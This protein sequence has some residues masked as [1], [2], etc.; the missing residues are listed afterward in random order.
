MP[1][2]GKEVAVAMPQPIVGRHIKERDLLYVDIPEKDAKLLRTKFANRLSESAQEALK[3]LV[4]LKRK[5]DIL[6]AI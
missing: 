5:T 2:E 4:E 1:E 3:E 6:W